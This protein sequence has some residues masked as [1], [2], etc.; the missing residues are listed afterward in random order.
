M[1]PMELN[2]II[3]HVKNLKDKPLPIA[4]LIEIR[5]MLTANIGFNLYGAGSKEDGRAALK[6][7]DTLDEMVFNA[8]PTDL[9]DGNTE[10]L[11]TLKKAI[12][13]ET[14]SER[15]EILEN[16]AKAAGG[17]GKKLKQEVMKVITDPDRYERFIP[18]HQNLLQETATG[19]TF[20]AF[21]KFNKIMRSIQ[22]Q[23]LA[24]QNSD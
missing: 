22:D 11:R 5:H 7:R 12:K 9:L 6:V 15:S 1:K 17:T 20:L 4:R 21:Q 18:D 23:A 14:L 8:G 13:L 16:V 19:W 24:I 3:A 10:G 2:T